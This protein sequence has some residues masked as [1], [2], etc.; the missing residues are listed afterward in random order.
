MKCYGYSQQTV[1]FATTESA[2]SVNA[3]PTIFLAQ[4]EVCRATQVDL[5]RVAFEKGRFASY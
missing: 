4:C 3:V 1:V 5:F 2:Y